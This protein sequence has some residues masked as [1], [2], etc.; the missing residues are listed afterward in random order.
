M[1]S[2]LYFVQTIVI[3]R[4]LI[5]KLH[6]HIALFHPLAPPRLGQLGQEL[7]KNLYGLPQRGLLPVLADGR[8]AALLGEGVD[9]VR[10]LGDGGYLQRV[11]RL[12]LGRVD[13]NAN[14]A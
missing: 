3:V 8:G 9:L 6:A 11:E 2:V 5:L 4:E 14:T 13:G 1:L 10:Q 7:L 12:H